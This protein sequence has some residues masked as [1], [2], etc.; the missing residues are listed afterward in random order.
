MMCTEKELTF[1]TFI[2]YSLSEAWNKTP[3]E[4]YKV[5]NSAEILDGYIIES[6]D[7]LHTLGKAYLVEDITELAGEKGINIQF[8]DAT[9]KD[10]ILNIKK[11]EL[12][13][14]IIVN[15]AEKKNIGI[16]KAMDMYYSSNTA[17]KIADMKVITENMD[18]NKL[19]RDVLRNKADLER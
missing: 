6:Y 4:V 16:R 9:N 3:A 17:V 8:G 7:V 12:E 10:K 2:F 5:L 13:D 1:S 14:A 15:I 11:R 19:A 18:V